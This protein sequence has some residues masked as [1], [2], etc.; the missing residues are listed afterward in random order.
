MIESIDDG[1]KG[2][3]EKMKSLELLKFFQEERKITQLSLASQVVVRPQ[4]LRV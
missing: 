3:Q 2:K 4:L 1:N